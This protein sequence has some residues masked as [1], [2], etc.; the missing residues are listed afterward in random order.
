MLIGDNNLLVKLEAF[1]D[2]PN[3]LS[4]G[5]WYDHRQNEMLN[6]TQLHEFAKLAINYDNELISLYQDQIIEYT[7]A[8]KNLTIQHHQAESDST[9]VTK[10]FGIVRFN[11]PTQVIVA[12]NQHDLLLSTDNSNVTL[13][14]WD[15]LDYRISAVRFGDDDDYFIL[16]NLEQFDLSQITSLQSLFN[17]ANLQHLARKQLNAINTEVVNA[18]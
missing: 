8:A 17:L 3:K 4:I 1:Y 11:Q 13:K 7:V 12:K 18:L 14:N 2:H 15:R 10:R 16:N 6:P 9:S 5:F